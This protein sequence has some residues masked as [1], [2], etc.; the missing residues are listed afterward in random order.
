MAEGR[1]RALRGATSVA[2]NEA[3]AIVDATTELL[4]ELVRVNGVDLED[5]VSIVFTSTT[6]LDAAFPAEGAR[7]AGLGGIPLLCAAEID[8]PGA[9]PRCVR[10]LMHL[11]SE[12]DYASLQ[13]V[14][15]G[16]ARRLRMDLPG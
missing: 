8:V 2:G 1:L 9:L 11:Y 6:D 12:R 14:Y 13:H 15:L 7:R 4:E 16:E 3:G 10:V 5:I